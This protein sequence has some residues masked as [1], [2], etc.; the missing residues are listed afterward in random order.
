MEYRE[1]LERLAAGK[2]LSAAEM[3]AVIDEVME[4][5]LT[6][7]QVGGLLVALRMKGE[8]AEEIGAAARSMRRHATRIDAGPP[9][10]VDTC[11]TGGDRAHTF[12][13]S[14]CAAFIAAGAGAR[15][16]KH[17]GRSVSSKCGSADVLKALGVNIELPP[18]RVGASVREVGIGFLFA[19][20]LHGA[21]KHAAGPRRELGVRTIF[22]I[23]GPLSNPAGADRQ[24]L[25]VFDGRLTPVLGEVLCQLGT[26][27]ALV[28]HGSDGLDEITGTGPT[29]VSELRDGSVQTRQFDPRPWLGAYCRPEDLRG[30]EAPENAAILTAILAGEDSPRARVC[31]LNGAAAILVAGLAEDFSDAWTLARQAVA[32]G[33]ARAKL[34]ALIAFGQA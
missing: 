6:P 3:E 4:G 16:A 12:N 24:L 31:L 5:R 10:V 22:N 23:L 29:Q 18:E 30:G 19:P 25:G 20:L 11:G 2:N 34:E 14:T 13:I 8:S 9:P 28:V 7:A 26:R 17:G 1:V 27:H 15:I 21:M 33:A 32:S